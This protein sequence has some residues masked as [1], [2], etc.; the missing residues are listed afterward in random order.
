MLSR[1]LFILAFCAVGLYA[2]PQHA[3]KPAAPPP[4][5]A[6]QSA[7]QTPPQ[8]PPQLTQ[9]ESLTFQN[10]NLQMQLLER[11]F[12]DLMRQVAQ[13]HPGY[14]LNPSTGALYPVAPPPAAEAAP[15]GSAQSPKGAR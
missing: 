15:P 13:E 14:A 3:A 6:A 8:A 9:V 10:I 1:R 12:Q 5:A 7:P 4:P 2:W 11:Q